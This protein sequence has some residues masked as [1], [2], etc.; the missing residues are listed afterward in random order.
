VIT[1]DGGAATTALSVAENQTAVTTITSTDVDGGAPIYS[2]IGG[3]D[4]ALFSINAAGV[5]TFNTA[6]DREAPADAG[7]NNVYD[8]I[9]QVADGNGGF[10]AQAIAITVT[11]VNEAPVITSDGGGATAALS[12]AEN[13]TAVTT[14]TST[15]VDGSTPIYNIVGGAD[16]ALFSINAAGVLTFNTAPD[17]EAPTDAGA[18][19]IYDVIIQVADGNGGFN[20]QAIAITVTNINEAPVITVPGAQSVNED[21]ALAISG[22]SINDVDLG[23]GNFT[24]QLTVGNGTLNVSLSG[25]ASI[26]AGASGSN[27]LTLLG[28]QAQI[29]AALATVSYQGNLDFNGADTLQIVTSDGAL[30]DAKVV[31][32][33]VNAV[34]D[35]AVIEGTKSGSVVEAG[36][37]ANAQ[38]NVPTAAG[39]LTAKDV[40]NP[41][42]MFI[43]QPTT[44]SVSGFGS[45]Q[46]TASGDWLYTLD[47]NNP[48]VEALG[49]GDTLTDSFAVQ[50]A[51]GTNQVI[52]ISISGSNDSALTSGVTSGTVIEAGGIANGNVGTPTATGALVAKDIDG[53]ASFQALPT[54]ASAYGSYQVSAI[55]VW[56][57]TLDNTNPVVQAL[58]VS[59]T[60]IDTFTV[61]TV[62]NTPQVITIVIKGSTDLVIGD[63]NSAGGPIGGN[64]NDDGVRTFTTTEEPANGGKSSSA[65]QS[66]I[67][68]D[69]LGNMAD[70]FGPLNADVESVRRDGVRHLN[71]AIA[72]QGSL[73]FIS[74]LSMVVRQA[75]AATDLTGYDFGEYTFQLSRFAMQQQVSGRI[76]DTGDVNVV[77]Q[78]SGSEDARGS[79][80]TTSTIVRTAGISLTLGV[81]AWALRSGGLVAAM[82]SSL[83]AWRQVDLLPILGDPGKRKAG[84]DEDR[85][86]EAAREERAVVRMLGNRPRSDEA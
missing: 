80:V 48:A 18:N 11:N 78:D 38:V 46:I 20:T 74:T 55:G 4:A 57:Y 50:S 49:D 5:L 85:D 67:Q 1:S 21:T 3:A 23:A 32:I 53:S 60:L 41:A 52:T 28:T 19:N 24:T 36:G 16:Q 44:A 30:S 8:V 58:N 62:D 34:N 43:A 37:V 45:Y 17:R 83:P 54:A 75:N 10:D 7:S 72:L 71:T 42:N 63:S 33:G 77:L 35:A 64:L 73:G 82:L 13:Q 25:G 68:F 6:P 86:V 81:A 14:V 76:S 61:R 69:P 12:V 51:D 59:D 9:V 31:V 47:N 66:A 70:L 22:L 84:W 39:T 15:D 40:D 79:A 26:S 56:T 29:N 27:T 65:K 2:I